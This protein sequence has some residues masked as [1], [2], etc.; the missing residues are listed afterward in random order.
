MAARRV[1]RKAKPKTPRKKKTGRGRA[2]LGILLPLLLVT[3]ALAGAGV[4]W[5]WPRCSG[6]ACPSVAALRTYSPPQATRV[7]D[8]SGQVLAHLAPERRIVV[9]LGRIPPTVAGAFLAVEDRRFFRHDGVDWHRAVGA[10]VRNVRDMRFSEGFSTLTMQLARNVFPEQLSRAKTLRRKAWEIMLAR[11]IE[12]EFSKDEILEMYLNQIYLGNGL[13]GVEAA[14][15]GY[16]GRSATELTLAQAALLAALPK[17]P[18]T[19]DPRRNPM[20]AIDRRNLVLS[21][22]VE[23]GV[24]TP[25]EA[26]RAKGEG[27][28]LVPPPEARGQAPYFVAEVRRELRER[29]GPDAESDGLKVFTGIDG[30]MQAKA[31]DEL[32]KQLRAV[33]DD[34]LG[35]FTGP[36]CGA[37]G[38]DDPSGC[39]QGLF[40]AMDVHTGDV[41]A[42]VGGRDFAASQFD[43]VTQAKRQSGSAFK[44]FVYA[45]ALE[46]GVPITTQ[47]LGPGMQDAEG[48]YRPADHVADSV[49]VDLRDGLRI[50][51]NRAA[52]A[53][54][55]RV[56]VGMVVNTAKR[57]GLSTP[58]PPYP[59]T[60]LGASSVIPLELVAAYA[61]FANEGVRVRPRLIKRV[62]DA[63]GAVLYQAPV[64]RVS[65]ISPEVAFLATSLM[66]DVVDHGTGYRVRESLPWSVPAAGKTGTTNE[67]ADA[68]FVGYTP[69]I[70]AG[71]WMGFDKPQRIMRGADGGKLAAPVWGKV[72]AAYYADHAAPAAWTPPAGV[73]SVAVD[74]STGERATDACPP[75]N[76]KEEWYLA[77]TEPVNFCELHQPGPGGWLRRQLRSF[78]DLLG[79]SAEPERDSVPQPYDF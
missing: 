2:V 17:A 78:G 40:V 77:G 41:L 69:D 32:L 66:R 68:W 36:E 23:S 38:G 6:D 39:L 28:G 19:Y 33:E 47:L 16:F 24:A 73:I 62:E 31:N 72:M 70:A 21:I 29:F 15:H 43:R 30:A 55:E 13:Y 58:I 46:E 8:R 54:G 3:V 45:A 61:G 49:S 12:R 20:A 42:L 25:D 5:L 51:S 37:R 52:V 53:L 60:F 56:G 74:V 44:P 75:E 7:L 76:V 10:L 48:D 27:L 26:E 63:S 14:A 9:S 34:E 71:V 79:G 67:S 64:E 57:L 11:Q 35:N 4:V 59:S 22:M 50:S 65:A 1:T 18:S